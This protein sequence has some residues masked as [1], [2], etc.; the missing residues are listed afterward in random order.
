MA[1][2]DDR[3]YRLTPEL[4]Q[5]AEQLSPVRDTWAEQWRQV[6]QI[7]ESIAGTMADFVRLTQPW[8]EASSRIPFPTIVLPDIDLKRMF[9][10]FPSNLGRYLSGIETLAKFSLTDGI[11][12]SWVP[13]PDILDALIGTSCASERYEVLIR[14]RDEILDDCSQVLE[15]HAGAWAN[16]ALQAIRAVRSGHE[17]AAQSHAANLIDS[18]ILDVFADPTSRHNTRAPRKTAKTEASK[19]VDL[20]LSLQAVAKL[21]SLRPV[22]AAYEDWYPGDRPPMGFNRHATAHCVGDPGVFN[23]T[24]CIVAIMLATSLTCQFGSWRTSLHPN[25]RRASAATEDSPKHS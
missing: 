4:R 11:P 10:G 21:L 16:A 5:L 23:E 2:D 14:H 20:N 25:R 15:S 17:G 19:V 3:L 1:D 18:V 9:A 12:T 24:F 8:R 22:L 7:S 6:N 13:R